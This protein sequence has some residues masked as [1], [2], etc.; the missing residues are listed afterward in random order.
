MMGALFAAL[1]VECELAYSEDSGKGNIEHNGYAPNP[2]PLLEVGGHVRN[3]SFLRGLLTRPRQVLIKIFFDTLPNLPI[4]KHTFVF[5]ERDAEEIRASIDRV[6]RHLASIEHPAQLP[7][8]EREFDVFGEYDED[9]IK[10]VLDIIEQRPDV[11]LIRVN[12]RDLVENPK[13]EFERINE[14][15]ELDVDKAA[16]VID[17]KYYRARKH[18]YSKT[19]S[20]G[21]RAYG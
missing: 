4:G 14:V 19:R 9:D 7:S 16:S 2:T 12:Y 20:A 18:D 17:S 15:L 6:Y 10:H 5:M 11:T 8:T 1:K 13:R 3:G 21:T